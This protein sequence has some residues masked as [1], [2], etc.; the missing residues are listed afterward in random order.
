MGFD[1]TA[2]KEPVASIPPEPAVTKTQ[3]APA[4]YLFGESEHGIRIIALVA[5]AGIAVH[6]L[7]RFV[8]PIGARPVANMPLFVTLIVGGLPL[9]VSLGKRLWAGEFGSDFL[10]AISIVTAVLLRQYL[11]ASI[12][13][14]MLSGGSALEEFATRRFSSRR[15]AR[16]SERACISGCARH[17]K[18]RPKHA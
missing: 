4:V 12:V 8:A 18:P 15:R 9:L 13:V 5:A 6:L 17:V 1:L 7:L 14:L 11:V 3:T 2:R 10:A 16:R